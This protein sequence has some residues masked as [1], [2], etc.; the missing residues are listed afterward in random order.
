MKKSYMA[1]VCAF[2]ASAA[3][4]GCSGEPQLSSA[5][6]GT[7]EAKV[8]VAASNSETE[9]LGGARFVQ[10]IESGVEELGGRATDVTVDNDAQ[11]LISSGCTVIVGTDPSQLSQAARANE[12]ISF[13]LVG[14]S[15]LDEEGAKTELDNGLAVDFRMDEASYLAGYAAAG[16]TTTGKIGVVG[17]ENTPL[18]WATMDAFTQ[19]VDAYNLA[20]GTSII[21]SGW[22]SV[23]QKG[24]ISSTPEAA[25]EQ[26]QVMIADGVDIILAAAGDANTGVSEAAAESD[27]PMM[28]VITTQ[29]SIGDTTSAPADSGQ[30]ADSTQSGQEAQSGQEP[31][32]GRASTGDKTESAQSALQSGNTTQSLSSSQAKTMLAHPYEF[33]DEYL[34]SVG[35]NVL[36]GVV[37]DFETV[38]ADVLAAAVDGKTGQ[39]TQPYD[40][41]SGT[42]AL[43]GFGAY[44]PLISDDLRN[45]LAQQY[46]QIVGGQVTVTTAF[47]VTDR[48]ED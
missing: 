12:N 31:Q 47:D 38:I 19:G 29:A 3:V 23:S 16:M 30:S 17:G 2:A 7:A 1:A 14:S 4:S 27:Q 40:L 20:N 39:T 10:A 37:T 48:D 21:V 11:T 44:D 22:D 36:T 43:A 5:E 6:Y 25:K 35:A 13:V 45:A 46:T 26:A 33:S 41:A 15:F 34:K 24:S 28:R 32:S 18:T 9:L 42:V 8:C